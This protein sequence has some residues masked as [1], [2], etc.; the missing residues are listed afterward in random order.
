MSDDFDDDSFFV[1]DSFLA[2][3]DN[4]TASATSTLNPIQQTTFSRTTSLPAH[5]PNLAPSFTA[6]SHSTGFSTARNALAGPSKTTA[7]AAANRRAAIAQQA[8]PIAGPTRFSRLVSKPLVHPSSDDF[9]DIDLP[10]GSLD[11]LDTIASTTKAPSTSS[12]TGRVQAIP[13]S[14]LGMGRS[15][16]RHSSGS[17]G[18]QTHLNFR[19]ENQAT[20]GKRWDRTAFAESGRR[21]DAAKIKANKGKRFDMDDDEVMS[22]EEDLGELLVPGPKPLVDISELSCLG[23][24][25]SQLTFVG[26]S[27]GP[28]KHLLDPETKGTYIYPTNRSKRDYQYE[29]V[30]GC[31]TDN[32]LVALPTGL[33]KT[34]VAGVVMLNCG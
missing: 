2:E 32:C 17:D 33:G 16:A 34:F 13:S 22:E 12:A 5:R 10:T 24:W 8:F 1:D 3:V 27:Y 15:L 14:R 4:I 28:P 29:I 26:S 25:N 19:R 31:F 21:V 30:R 11:F 23:S 9:D 6:R 18:F 7:S 20:K